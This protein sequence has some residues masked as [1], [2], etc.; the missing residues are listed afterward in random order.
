M[1]FP[2]TTSI[3]RLKSI[4][5]TRYEALIRGVPAWSRMDRSRASLGVS[6]G[7]ASGGENR[8]EKPMKTSIPGV[9]SASFRYLCRPRDTRVCLV[10][11]RFVPV[12]ICPVAICEPE[13]RIWEASPFI[14][15]GSPNWR[16]YPFVSMQPGL[17][18]GVSN[19]KRGSHWRYDPEFAIEESRRERPAIAR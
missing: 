15:F 14:G 3:L 16:A 10:N 8:P 17:R 11:H 2:K 9:S 6:I 13:V 4:R 7:L 19:G 18:A 12:P 1:Q 5:I